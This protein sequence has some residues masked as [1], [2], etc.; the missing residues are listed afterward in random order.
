MLD[1]RGQRRRWAS[2]VTRGHCQNLWHSDNVFR[3]LAKLKRAIMWVSQSKIGYRA[4]LGDH[5]S[6]SNKCFSDITMRAKSLG[7][8]SRSAHKTQRLDLDASRMCRVAV[9]QI[10]GHVLIYDLAQTYQ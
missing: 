4:D 10:S 8:P 2:V 9:N 1:N 7:R 3:N 6:A 5:I